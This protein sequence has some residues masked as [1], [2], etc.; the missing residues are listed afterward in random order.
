M[1]IVYCQG[2]VLWALNVPDDNGYIKNRPAVVVVD[3]HDT[4]DLAVCVAITTSFPDPP[5]ASSIVLPYSRSKKC[6]TGLFE[7]CVAKCD[8]IVEVSVDDIDHRIGHLPSPHLKKII[9]QCFK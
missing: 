5:P 1:A 2:T 4:D 9:E 8:W 6:G 7:E 3:F